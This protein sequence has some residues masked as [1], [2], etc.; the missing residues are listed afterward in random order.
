MSAIRLVR[1]ITA[2][3]FASCL[4]GAGMATGQTTANPNAGKKP[5]ATITLATQPTP[6]AAGPTTFTVVAKD[7]N[8]TPITGADVSVEFV[9]PPMG[10]MGEM[11]NRV[12]K[13]TMAVAI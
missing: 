5:E 10:A 9:M 8:A 7:A 11:R 3:T 4:A 6:P 12:A 1:S 13:V 2:V